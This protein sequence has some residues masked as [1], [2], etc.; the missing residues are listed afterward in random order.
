MSVGGTVALGTIVG[1][2]KMDLRL[3]A[4]EAA[5]LCAIQGRVVIDARDDRFTIAS[6]DQRWRQGA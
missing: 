2:V 1:V 5:V 4:T 6:L 3:V